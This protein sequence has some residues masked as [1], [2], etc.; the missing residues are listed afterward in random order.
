[1]KDYL[2]ITDLELWTNLGVS[3]EERRLEQRVLLSIELSL[4]T[5]VAAKHDDI[6]QSVNYFDLAEDLRRTLAEKER[7]TIERL[8]EDVARLVLR[9]YKPAFVTV[10]VKKFALPGAR[11][12]N[13]TITRS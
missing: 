12:V 8:A 4:E 1:M 9:K 13:L 11:S 5:Q 10:T 2:T 7:K 3:A 6:R